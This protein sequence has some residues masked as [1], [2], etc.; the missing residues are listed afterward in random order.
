MQNPGFRIWARACTNSPLGLWFVPPG[1]GSLTKVNTLGPHPSSL[2]TV[3]LKRQPKPSEMLEPHSNAGIILGRLPLMWTKAELTKGPH[4]CPAGPTAPLVDL[5]QNQGR[6]GPLQGL[7]QT[8]KA[9]ELSLQRMLS[10]EL[11]PGAVGSRLLTRLMD[12]IPRRR[13]S[14]S[15]KMILAGFCRLLPGESDHSLEPLPRPKDSTATEKEL[16]WTCP[17]PNCLKYKELAEG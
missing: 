9:G 7:A 10:Q 15:P 5:V 4:S 17:A 8:K 1:V 11:H 14:S 13:V 16:R 12:T 3:H 2:L 6:Y